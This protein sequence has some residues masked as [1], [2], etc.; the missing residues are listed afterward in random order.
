MKKIIGF[1]F[2]M[3]ILGIS[4][5]ANSLPNTPIKIALKPAVN[6]K[7][8]YV[9]KDNT[10]SIMS[11]KGIDIHIEA[12]SNYDYTLEYRGDSAGLSSFR[13]VLNSIKTHSEQFGMSIDINTDSIVA[14]TSKFSLSNI[15]KL[16][17]AIT[18]QP[19]IIYINKFG[20]IYNTNGAK[21]ICN[22]AF[23]KSE[24]NNIAKIYQNQ[25]NEHLLTSSLVKL[26]AYL[27]NKLIEVN[28]KWSK[29]DS[30]TISSVHF[31]SISN[32]QLDK[33]DAGIANIALNSVHSYQGPYKTPIGTTVDVT[34]SGDTKGI[35]NVNTATGML[36]SFASTISFDAKM[37]MNEIEIPMKFTSRSTVYTK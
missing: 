3:I 20:N 26:F 36:N 32:F 2:I 9:I 25:L 15:S 10:S 6:S 27:P 14:D 19:F 33:L 16:Y 34:L 22:K 5:F 11:M 29:N 1:F 30:I 4:S 17:K 21:E 13:V 28:D 24:L 18:G 7:V 23:S 31:S 35:Y 37:S 8:N 12:N